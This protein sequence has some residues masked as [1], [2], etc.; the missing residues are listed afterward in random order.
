MCGLVLMF[1]LSIQEARLIDGNISQT[2]DP[3]HM[4]NS[5]FT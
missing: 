4:A 1:E 5:Y 3:T 2:Q